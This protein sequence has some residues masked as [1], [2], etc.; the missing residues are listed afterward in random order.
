LTPLFA[1]STQ[2]QSLEQNGNGGQRGPFVL[3]VAIQKGESRALISS[4]AALAVGEGLTLF[5]NKSFLLSSVNWAVGNDALVSIPPKARFRPSSK[6]PMR[7][8]DSLRWFR[9]W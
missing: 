3:A 5:G 9:F 4:S 1:S 7:P 8:R 2:S 6:C